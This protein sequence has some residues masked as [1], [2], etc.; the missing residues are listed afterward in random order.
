ML[1][2]LKRI[3]DAGARGPDWRALAAWARDGGHAIKRVAEGDGFVV[4]GRYAETPWRLEWG[5]SQRAYIETRELRLRVEA[6]LP[7]DLQMLLLSRSLAERL[8]RE[9]FEQFTQTT[10]TY[11][12]TSA[13]EEMRWLAMFSRAHLHSK[14]VRSRFAAVAMEPPAATAWVEPEFATRLES[15]LLLEGDPPFTVM[16]Q[17]GRLYLR[18]GAA[19]VT[20]SALDDALAVGEVAVRH[21]RRVVDIRLASGAWPSTQSSAWPTLGSRSTEAPP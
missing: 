12:D 17:R 15:A 21:A 2:A 13:P 6:D 14:S 18:V 5:P 10:R 20:P 9:T 3:F 16:T 19:R 11:V 1:D 8:E 4:E 7:A